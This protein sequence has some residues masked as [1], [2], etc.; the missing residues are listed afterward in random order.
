MQYL[1][2]TFQEKGGLLL[3]GSQVERLMND[4]GFVDVTTEKLKVE[5]GDWGSG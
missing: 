3:D 5:I 4:A 2:E 1:R